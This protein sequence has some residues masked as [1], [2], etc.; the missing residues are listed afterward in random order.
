MRRVNCRELLDGNS[1]PSDQVQRAYRELA[2]IHR[3]LGDTRYI[4]SAIR[5]D[6]LPVRRVLDVG[7]ATGVM[8]AEVQRRLAV[9]A[10]GVDL[11]PRVRSAPHLRIVRADAVHEPLPHADVAFSMHVVHHLGESELQAM[12]RNVGRYC[13]RFLILDLVR[14]PL[15]LAL[16][17]VF[18]GPLVSYVTKSDGEASIRRSYTASELSRLTSAALSGTGASFRQRVSPI[19]FRQL[20]DIS[21]RPAL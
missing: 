5:H 9:E 4:L 21:Y 3:W 19:Y 1:L 12:I 17:R 7:C 6:P 16:F 14:H 13:R 10:I 11:N 2:H 18:V 20:V 15:P 8:L